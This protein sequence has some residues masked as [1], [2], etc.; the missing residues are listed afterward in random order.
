MLLDNEMA[1]RA[2]RDLRQVRDTK[3]LVALTEH[4]KLAPDSR[5]DFT[6]D[7]CVHFIKH[8]QRRGVGLREDGLER[9]H[10]ARDFAAGG[11]FAQ[12]QRLLTRVGSKENFNLAVAVLAQ[13]A[14]GRHGDLQ[15]GLFEAK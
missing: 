3:H 5:A 9:E 2:R 1:A 4:R 15:T 12:W 6:A 7:V 11:D 13:F 8:E 10:H 14:S